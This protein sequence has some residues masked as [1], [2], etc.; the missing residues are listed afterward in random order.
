MMA[1]QLCND[2]SIFLHLANTDARRCPSVRLIRIS[3]INRL[4]K[5]Q[6]DLG[7]SHSGSILA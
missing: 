6:I 2:Y 4:L 5:F 1:R 3:S 7:Q